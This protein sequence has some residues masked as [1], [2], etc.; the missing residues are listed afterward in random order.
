MHTTKT[1]RAETRSISIAA[2]PAAVLA[3]VADPQR[4]PEW[5]PAFARGVQP[6]GDHWLIDTREGQARITVRVSPEHGTVDL[7]GATD[8]TRGA[9]SRVVHNHDGSEYLFTLFFPDGTTETA[10]AQQMATVEDELEAVRALCE[11]E[12]GRTS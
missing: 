2:P 6:D 4:L 10:I 12:A 11:A 8:P 1:D 7:L 5:A 3:L 9:F